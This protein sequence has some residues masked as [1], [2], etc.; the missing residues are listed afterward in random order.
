[1]SSTGR[2]V[3]VVGSRGGAGASCLAAVV[4]KA[5]QEQTKRGILVD[6]CE[7]GPGLEVLLGI[8]SEPGARW[9]EMEA[10][11]GDIDGSELV[12]AL[13]QWQGLPVLSLSRHH[14][15]AIP[16][17]VVLDV[18]AG[19]L[20]NGGIVVIDLPNP[21]SWSP[22]IRA[23]VADADQVLIATPDSTVGIAGAVV[24]AAALD[25]LGEDQ[26]TSNS[27]RRRRGPQTDRALA[28]RTRSGSRVGE[29]EV[30]KLVGLPVMVRFRDDRNLTTAIELGAGPAFKSA[31]KLAKAGRAIAAE[32][33]S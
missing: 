26:S 33:M 24:V 4:A 19:L 22:A 20:R 6:L 30:S 9:A 18:C 15:R 5:V 28:L 31:K 13:P 12:L 7:G 29:N 21:S 2:L 3:V 27:A 32:V 10:A 8:E 1:M 17:E 25:G 14:A 11:R 16:D 23:L